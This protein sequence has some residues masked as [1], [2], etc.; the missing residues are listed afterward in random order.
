MC[1]KDITWHDANCLPSRHTCLRADIDRRWLFFRTF[2]TLIRDNL[3]GRL[4]RGLKGEPADIT[5]EERL[6]SSITKELRRDVGRLA[7][8]LQLK[9][10]E[11]GEGWM[12]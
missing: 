6:P 8:C 2:P 11:S 4:P 1:V 5:A 9:M 7:S 3:C 12:W 10:P